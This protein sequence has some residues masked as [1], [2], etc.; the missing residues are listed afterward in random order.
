[1]D[2]IKCPHCGSDEILIISDE[3][4]LRQSCQVCGGLVEQT[5]D[6]ARVAEAKPKQHFIGEMMKCLMCG[7]EQQHI[8]GEKSQWTLVGEEPFLCYVCPSC[9]QDS[10]QA[11]RGHWSTVYQKVMRR[12]I[13]VRERH[14]RGMDN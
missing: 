11:K 9:L 4:G 6:A 5:T 2:A 13:R 7:K 12:Y 8:I 14:M 1:M 3:I 10:E